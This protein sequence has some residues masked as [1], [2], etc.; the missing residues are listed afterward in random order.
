[1]PKF[2]YKAHD[3]QNR[4]VFSTIDGDSVDDVLEKLTERSLT[5]VSVE[6]LN[7]D[8]SNKNETFAQK[9][10]K[11]FARQ[12]HRVPYRSVV[13]FTRQLATMIEGGVPLSR[14]LEQL[15]K[16]E[17]AA[18]KKTITKVNEDISMGFSFSDAIAR[19]PG[20]F[21]TM[22]VSVI[23]SGEVSGALDSVLNQLA[24]YMENVET[25]KSKVKAAMRYP[26][27]IAGFITVLVTGILW[28]LVPVFENMYAGFG[29][30]LPV[31][32]LLLINISHLIR[33]NAPLLVVVI[34]AAIAAFRAGMTNEKFQ[35]V[36]HQA[37]LKVP[38]FGE[39]IRK[40]ILA[41][42]SRT[43][44]LLMENG[45]PILQ[46]IEISGAVVDSKVYSNALEKVFADLRQGETLSVSLGKSGEFPVL[47]EQLVSTGEES[48][49]VDVLLRKAAEFYEREIRNVVDSLAAIIEPFLIIVLGAIVGGILIALYLPVF[50]I[51][52]LI[53]H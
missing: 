49:K 9:F 34:I 30:K 23:R 20:A 36:V 8:G 7:F 19:H 43:M 40:N 38:V 24:N 1:M 50:M 53:G 13:F 35:T 46:A 26:M 16:S 5:V 39:I 12:M 15:A 25:L 51:G 10:N 2:A 22:F 11:G 18:F 4:V 21:N 48:G 52:K 33:N 17:K 14:A 6:E 32:T 44:A 29:A 42:F 45:T 3:A 41:A 37:I 28:K 47:I 27:F 31:P